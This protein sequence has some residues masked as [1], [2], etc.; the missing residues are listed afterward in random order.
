MKARWPWWKCAMCFKQMTAARIVIIIIIIII[1]SNTSIVIVFI[2]VMVNV[3][4]R[5]N[6]ISLVNCKFS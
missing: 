5:R 3:I 2:I 6:L 1:N 4:S